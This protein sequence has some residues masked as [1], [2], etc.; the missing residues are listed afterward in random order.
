MSHK[1]DRRQFI[2]QT[3]L[4]GA[5][6]LAVAMHVDPRLSSKAAAAANMLAAPGWK[7]ITFDPSDQKYR[8]QFVGLLKRT[9]RKYKMFDDNP[10]SEGGSELSQWKDHQKTS[11]G[12]DVVQIWGYY[13][14][15]AGQKQLRRAFALSYKNEADKNYR[16]G[17]VGVRRPA[18][19]KPAEIQDE[20]EFFWQILTFLMTMHGAPDPSDFW[21]DP[22]P[23][24]H[25][26]VLYPMFSYIRA[27]R[28]TISGVQKMCLVQ[29]CTGSDC[30]TRVNSYLRVS[31][32]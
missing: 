4:T 2:N 10:L 9:G 19:L 18:N 6:G 27:G 20:L 15:Q 22:P 16:L 29:E 5:A 12:Q 32:P 8:D 30:N 25:I 1:L 28:F 7:E 14:N 3:T 31:Q 23:C 21:F 26:G 24:H 13:K 17:P 11:L